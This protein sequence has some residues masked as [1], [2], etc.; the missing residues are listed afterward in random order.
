MGHSGLQST[1][2]YQD[3]T[4]EQKKAAIETLEDTITKS[5]TKG[6]NYLKTK[7]Q[8]QCLEQKPNKDTNIILTFY[9]Q[10]ID[11]AAVKPKV[12]VIEKFG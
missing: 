11:Y 8:L 3:V 1:M 12:E 2:V 4:E 10:S 5:M 9:W 7:D 6:G